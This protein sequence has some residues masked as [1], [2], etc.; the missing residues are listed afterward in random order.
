MKV[1]ENGSFW[2]V[3]SRKGRREVEEMKQEEGEI[4]GSEVIN[5]YKVIY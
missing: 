5:L 3:S 1:L 2:R 4:E